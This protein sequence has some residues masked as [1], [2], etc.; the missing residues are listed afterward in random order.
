MTPQTWTNVLWTLHQAC[1][2]ESRARHAQLAA[3][4]G[5]S[6]GRGRSGSV[7]RGASGLPIVDHNMLD[8]HL[9]ASADMQ[10]GVHVG[11]GC[12]VCCVCGA[13]LG[14]TD[15]RFGHV[16]SNLRFV[17]FA[18]HVQMEL[19]QG[20]VLGSMGS[21]T[22][23]V[24]ESTE[25]QQ[26]VPLLPGHTPATKVCRMCTLEKPASDYKRARFHDGL[27]HICT[28]C[29]Q[30]SSPVVMAM[31][32]QLQHLRSLHFVLRAKS[33]QYVQNQ[34]ELEEPT[35]SEK[36]CNKCKELLPAAAFNR[37]RHTTDHLEGQCKACKRSILASV[38]EP[39]VLEKQCSKCKEVK[40][41]SAF[42]RYK[43]TQDGLQSQCKAC[44]KVSVLL[45][46]RHH[47]PQCR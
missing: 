36:V 1:K 2:N 46:H 14:H 5:V 32:A 24:T 37:N 16:A 12:F 10:Y 19:P 43:R 11:S 34:P 45:V 39:T 13:S 9:Q 30:A 28:L 27:M 38:D 22:A 3:A 21:W 29:M 15:G 44:M 25:Q 47:S 26:P 18:G 41:A 7:K 33:G 6:V 42:D 4:G 40:Q 20:A 31:P 8:L 35:V 23:A 17:Q